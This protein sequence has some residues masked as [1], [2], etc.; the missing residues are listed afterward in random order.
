MKV[1]QFW[2]DE[3]MFTV[4]FY[5]RRVIA[6]DVHLSI[7]IAL[8]L[9]FMNLNKKKDCTNLYMRYT[10]TEAKKGSQSFSVN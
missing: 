4:I 5:Q 7:A 6:W 3:G 10:E 8:T 1:F 9:P 2:G